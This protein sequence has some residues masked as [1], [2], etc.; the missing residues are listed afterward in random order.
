MG[1]KVSGKGSDR[2]CTVRGKK[3][4]GAKSLSKLSKE[5]ETSP[6]ALETPDRV[7][8]SLV[9]FFQ[10]HMNSILCFSPASHLTRSLQ[11]R[12]VQHQRECRH[13]GAHVQLSVSQYPRKTTCILNSPSIREDLNLKVE[14]IT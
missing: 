13:A 10:P 14:A 9:S 1:E 5:I 4:S 8:D 3:T 12:Q 11:E 7:R 6:S 2:F